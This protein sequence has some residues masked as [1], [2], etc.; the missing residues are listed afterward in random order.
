MTG[1]SQTARSDGSLPRLALFE[2]RFGLRIGVL[3]AGSTLLLLAIWLFFVRQLFLS[4]GAASFDVDFRVFWAAARLAVSGE[5]L[6]AF[7]PA[8]L[9]EIHGIAG[10]DWLPWVYPPTFLLI[11]L[12]LGH[13]SFFAAWLVFTA[14]SLLAIL[15]AIRPLA[16]GHRGLWAAIALAPAMLPALLLGQVSVLWAAGLVTVLAALQ[17]GWPVL[18]GVVCGL[19]TIKPQLGVMLAIALVAGRQWKTIGAA[20]SATLVFAALAT[21]AFGL[22]YWPAMLDAAQAH[23]DVV[24]SRIAEGGFMV[25]AYSFLI[26]LGLAEPSALGLQWLL[27]IVAAITVWLAWSSPLIGPDLKGATLLTAVLVSSPYLW[28]GETAL[29]APALLLFLRADALRPGWFGYAFGLALLLGAAP[30]ILLHLLST[31]TEVPVRLFVSPVILA[32]FGL[33]LAT[34]ITRRRAR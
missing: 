2:G 13:L 8:R 30:Y 22:A 32:A 7:D 6:A 9:T 1:A 17:A 29:L 18:A 24:R 12:P 5:P 15:L 10:D 19:L 27:V 11:L 20:V 26:A 34:V 23:M 3:S 31:G 4:G 14:M 25:S 33:S 21:F 16:A 28:Y